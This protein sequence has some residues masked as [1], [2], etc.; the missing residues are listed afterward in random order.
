MQG[1]GGSAYISGLPFYTNGQGV[2]LDLLLGGGAAGGGFVLPSLNG[3][4]YGGSAGGGPNW[5]FPLH[6]LL[7]LNPA[8]RPGDSGVGDYWQ[9]PADSTLGGVGDHWQA[10]A[11]SIPQLGSSESVPRDKLGSGVDECTEEEEEG[12]AVQKITGQQPEAQQ[13]DADADIDPEPRE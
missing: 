3:G 10:P 13:P 8:V 9:A 12:V 5:P 2:D 11:D 6:S 4:G 1:G 7:L